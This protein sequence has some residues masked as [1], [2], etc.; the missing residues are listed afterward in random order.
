[1]T[2]GRKPGSKFGPYRKRRTTE[3]RFLAFVIPEPN[4]GCH[5]WEGAIS[6]Y[7]YGQL[8]V[9]GKIMSAPRLAL[10]LA[11]RPASRE[12]WVLHHCDI[13][14]CVNPDHLFTGTRGDNVRD[15][16]GKG[17]AVIPRGVGEASGRAK[18]TEEAVAA[19]RSSGEQTK[20]LAARYGVSG[21]CIRYIRSGRSWNHSMPVVSA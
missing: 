11:G 17:R 4:S 6:S 5:L 1:V 18:L 13:P 20:H 8:R 3:E 2:K 7:G 21:A 16:V 12:Q 9:D 10:E 15:M 19:I 14:M